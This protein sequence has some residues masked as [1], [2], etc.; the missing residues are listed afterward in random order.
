MQDNESGGIAKPSSPPHRHVIV[1]SSS[2]VIGK[3]GNRVKNTLNQ[4]NGGS[5]R[6]VDDPERESASKGSEDDLEK[7]IKNPHENDILLG[8]GRTSWSHSGNQHFRA[9]VGVHLKSYAESTNRSEKTKTVD[10]IYDEIIQS[11]GR[12][13][14]LDSAS[15]TWHQV[16]K[17]VAR[18]K[19]AHTLRDAVTLRIKLASPDGDDSLERRRFGAGSVVSAKNSPSISSIKKQEIA[20]DRTPRFGVDDDE[21]PHDTASGK[22]RGGGD[23]APFTCI[24]PKT[25]V[26]L[27]SLL[28]ATAKS[29]EVAEHR[30]L[31]AGTTSQDLPSH[32]VSRPVSTC[33]PEI[34]HGK[35]P[36]PFNHLP[37]VLGQPKDSTKEM[38]DVHETDED[39]STGFS[40]MSLEW[41]GRSGTLSRTTISEANE[42]RSALHKLS[43]TFRTCKSSASTRTGHAA[44]SFNG[45]IISDGLQTSYGELPL[46]TLGNTRG[47]QSHGHKGDDSDCDVS[48][49][50]TSLD[51]TKGVSITDGDI[52]SLD[53][54]SLTSDRSKSTK[55]SSQQKRRSITDKHDQSQ[56]SSEK[57]TETEDEWRRTLKALR[58]M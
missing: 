19:I 1:P 55:N 25:E 54:F 58:G 39:F 22:E 16:G 34:Q 21:L 46:R 42:E 31:R 48:M 35:E 52:M 33:L 15:N 45:A 5:K 47:E 49:G 11:G 38:T 17:S 41:S 18:E 7:N 6:T 53:D 37:A 3:I 51:S 4:L 30:T 28:T 57:S 27:P 2:M 9:F 8:R 29:T 36:K 43:H 12:F 44:Y 10:L 40:A 56:N 50:A 20:S 32:S 23:D 14:K 26:G 24:E 13:L